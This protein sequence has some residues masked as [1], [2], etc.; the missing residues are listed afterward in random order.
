MGSTLKA[1]ALCSCCNS[2][3]ENELAGDIDEAFA[4]YVNSLYSGAFPQTEHIKALR[5]AIAAEDLP[6]PTN[7]R[8][9]IL[10]FD[11]FKAVGECL[12]LLLV[13]K[14]FGLDRLE[15]EFSI[16]VYVVATVICLLSE[17]IALLKHRRL[18]YF[19]RVEYN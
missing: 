16:N 17:S 2:A 7:N 11:W 12:L 10:N 8:D 14:V 9:T 19:H 5:E 15:S 13:D 3:F 18:G 6:P 4:S 1:W